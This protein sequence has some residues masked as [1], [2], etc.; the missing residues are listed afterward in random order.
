MSIISR[1]RV[2]AGKVEATPGTPE[3]LTAS[4]ASMVITE[5]QYKPDIQM[6]ERNLLGTDLS[7]YKSLIGA[8]AG[9]ISFKTEMKGGGAAGTAPALG[10]FLEGGGFG[11]TVNAGTSVEYDP[12]SASFDTLTLGI[13]ADDPASTGLRHLIAGAQPTS[14]RFTGKLGEPMFMEAEY[15]GIWQPT[16]DIAPLSPTLE[17]LAPPVLI[18][19]TFTVGGTALTIESVTIDYSPEV[20]LQTSIASSTGYNSSLFVNRKPKISF[21]MQQVRVAEYDVLG[22]LQDGTE[23][24]LVLT[25]GATAGNIVS[26]TGPKVQVVG[27]S[28]G[29]RNGVDT[30]QVE[31]M[32]NRNSGNDELQLTFT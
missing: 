28:E 6:F 25:V 23:G 17:V 4:E 19:A 11:E 10:V 22:N 20:S 13:Y 29:N 2:L 30:F 8:Q 32:L 7:P 27:V 26:F 16:V 24:A 14:L 1:L 9:T 15:R 3:T 5:A 21:D 31:G 18:G 12:I